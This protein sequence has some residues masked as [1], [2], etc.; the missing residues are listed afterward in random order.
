VV[1]AQARLHFFDTMDFVAP[2]VPLGLG[3]GRSATSS[4]ASCGASSPMP[5][6]AWSSRMRPVGHSGR[7]LEQLM[8]TAQIQRSSPPGCSTLRAPS[9]AAV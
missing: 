9:L 8:T 2:L 7:R 3:F 5:A 4:A 6:G 1:V